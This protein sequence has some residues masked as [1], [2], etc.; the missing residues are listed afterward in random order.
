MALLSMHRGEMMT[1][2]ELKSKASYF[3][4]IFPNFFKN[5][6]IVFEEYI[7]ELTKCVE[8]SG[9]DSYDIYKNYEELLCSRWL[10]LIDRFYSRQ[11]KKIGMEDL[12]LISELL[13]INSTYYSFYPH[14]GEERP[15]IAPEDESFSELI[16]RYD[17]EIILEHLTYANGYMVQPLELENKW[18][19]Q[20]NDYN[21][22]R[23]NFAIN[24][25]CW[26]EPC[27]VDLIKK[28][29][30]YGEVDKSRHNIKNDYIIKSEGLY[31]GVI[32]PGIALDK[33][34]QWT[35][36]FV[37]LTEFVIRGKYRIG[38]D[39]FDME[40][41]PWIDGDCVNDI[42][43][44]KGAAHSYQVCVV[45]FVNYIL[46]KDQTSFLKLTR[47]VYLTMINVYGEAK[48]QE[49]IFSC[50]AESIIGY[51]YNFAKEIFDD[52]K[53]ENDRN[54]KLN[55]LPEY[56]NTGYMDASYIPVNHRQVTI[57]S[58]ELLQEYAKK[59][60][61]KECECMKIACALKRGGYRR[62]DDKYVNTYF[63]KRDEYE[64]Y[65]I[66]YNKMYELAIVQEI[67]YILY[68]AILFDSKMVTNIPSIK[69]ICSEIQGFV[70]E[71]RGYDVVE[72]EMEKFSSKSFEL[73][74]SNYELNIH[75]QFVLILN[76]ELSATQSLDSLLNLKHEFSIQILNRGINQ[77]TEMLFED[78]NS[79]ILTMVEEKVVQDSLFNIIESELSSLVNKYALSVTNKID[80]YM[81]NDS[82]GCNKVFASIK[83]VL[84][85]AEFLYR[86]Y[87]LP[88][89]QV[90]TIADLPI[91]IQNMDFS[92]IALEYYI[93][94]EQL[95]N[96]L[97]FTPYRE[98]VLQPKYSSCVSHQ[99]DSYM[100]GYVGFSKE[101]HL[102]D[103]ANH[104]IKNSL[105]LGNLAFLYKD[106]LY[107]NGDLKKQFLQVGYY[108]NS[109]SL[110]MLDARNI[111]KKIYDIRELRNEAA[112]GRS[113]LDINRARKA[114]DV[115]FIH[116][117]NPDP[118]CQINIADQCHEVIIE[119]LRWFA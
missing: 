70:Y 104:K 66:I 77:E 23:L 114:Q 39:V 50:S 115:T 64:K 33:R 108:I 7:D 82:I 68:N 72:S 35:Q 45:Y 31:Q 27:D 41:L 87:V 109:L 25:E 38:E 86:K 105:E 2:E 100:N 16:E 76:S 34:R 21:D 48:I 83:K 47:L 30:R 54:I 1:Y 111:G 22:D 5:G 49:N 36:D 107:S 12:Y 19:F 112:H 37:E 52:C 11:L 40:S 14:A 71:D 28:F 53:K 32:H 9:C 85:T 13:S 61:D 103:F 69:R 26:G 56:H 116:T 101:K 74:D 91:E 4:R 79:K 117:P 94:L 51:I 113:P 95:V 43:I 97:L 88:Y 93:A 99:F 10:V 89:A 119:L 63:K 60:S 98:K 80:T 6:L 17:K 110:N 15:C 20:R 73:A 90:V 84:S 46:N 106:S 8:E 65:S 59:P 55:C 44:I 92:C 75:R 24:N 81:G 18:K 102:V 62:N 58:D 78:I 118:L 96:I 3:D 57:Y 42:D 67:L 29:F